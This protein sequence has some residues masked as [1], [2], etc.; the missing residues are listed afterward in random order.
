MDIETYKKTF[1]YIVDRITN[2]NN[3]EVPSEISL[4]YYT[5]CQNFTKYLGISQYSELSDYRNQVLEYLSKTFPYSFMKIDN[6]NI[7]DAIK[8]YVTSL[9]FSQDKVPFIILKLHSIKMKHIDK[10]NIRD[11]LEQE[12]MQVLDET[13]Q[14]DNIVGTSVSKYQNDNLYDI[15]KNI[16]DKNINSY[17]SYLINN[18]VFDDELHFQKVFSGISITKDQNNNQYINEGNHR[19]FTY[20]ALLTI[21]DFLNIPTKSKTFNVNATVYKSKVLKNKR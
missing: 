10:K 14:L 17:I 11:L 6:K 9:G 5:F 1:D 21:R 8:L 2:K 18:N 7:E 20:I 19:I 3:S 15:L 12:Q 13:V 16:N 4:E